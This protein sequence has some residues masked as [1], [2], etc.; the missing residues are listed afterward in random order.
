MK[1]AFAALFTIILFHFGRAQTIDTLVDVGGHKLHFNIMKGK[2]IP[3]LFESG[4]G[5]DGSAWEPILQDIYKATG[6]TLI[7]YDRAGLGQSEIDTTRISFKQEI[8]DLNKALRKL[9]YGKSYFLVAH[10]FGA[11]YASEFSNKN[12]GKVKGAVF[13]DVA[14]PCQL[15][16]EVATRIQN[17]ISEDNWN[18][19]KQYKVG[20]YYVLKNFPGILAYMSNRYISNSIPLTVIVAENYVPTKEIGETEQDMI[21]WKKCLRELGSLPNHKYIAT[22]NTDH[23]VWEKDPKTVVGEIVK[24]YNQTKI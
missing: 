7:T 2:G 21:N 9:G 14:T 4:N 3:I 18:L 5:D 8:K 22:K 16:N 20:L 15:N 13:I 6:A 1:Q 10:S 24:L 17:S 23:K 19:L 12:K 11:I